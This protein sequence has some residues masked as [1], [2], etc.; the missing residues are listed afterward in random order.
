MKVLLMTDL[1]GVAGVVSFEHQADPSGR[2]YEEARGLLTAE[3][4]AAV[5]GLQEA[6]MAEVLVVDG[7]G[8]GGITFAELH[9]AAGLLHGRPF[10]P[11]SLLAPIFAE[12]D[13]AVMIG[14]H[15]RAGVAT[16]NLSHT[17]NER[18]VEYYRLNGR[19]IGEIGQFALYC[20]GL[21]RPLIFLSGSEAAC[22]EAE[23]LLPGITTV[24]VKRGVSRGSAIAL[25]APEARQRIREGIRRAVERQRENPLPPL[26]WEGPYV[27]EI[28][29]H[30]T[31]V[32]DARVAQ[33]GVERVDG[34]TV[35][36]R[37][38]HILDLI[39]R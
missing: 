25:S 5:E 35:R 10:P 1:E 18:T 24:A 2:Y 3:V 20:G 21:G 28:R 17:Q 11:W 37:G 39:Y 26:S 19:E 36:L 8:A 14:Q 31:E 9:P 15:A 16:E 4:N 34:R 32:A 22:R 33:P 29:Y 13:V 7:H 30:F 27:L 38:D 6:G 12:Y 23:E